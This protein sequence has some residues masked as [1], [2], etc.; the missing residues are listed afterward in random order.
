MDHILPDGT[1]SLHAFLTIAILPDVP[2]CHTHIRYLYIV[3]MMTMVTTFAVSVFIITIRKR[4]CGQSLLTSL[5]VTYSTLSQ[6]I[7]DII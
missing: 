5:P 3:Q 2:D 7:L 6:F 1:Q 4:G